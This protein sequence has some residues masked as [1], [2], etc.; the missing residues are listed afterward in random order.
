MLEDNFIYLLHVLKKYASLQK[1]TRSQL[2]QEIQSNPRWV[3]IQNCRIL[4]KRAQESHM[5]GF[6][7]SAT[8]Y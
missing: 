3:N 5:D 1:L 7:Q 4:R 2:Q 6:I 8:P